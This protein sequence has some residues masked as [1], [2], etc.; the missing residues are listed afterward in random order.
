MSGIEPK[1]GMITFNAEGTEGGLYHSRKLHVPT[2][3]SGLTLGRGYDLRFKTKNEVTLDLTKIGLEKEQ[4]NQL[5]SATGL[6]GQQAKE[7]ISEHKL[8]SFELSPQQQVKLFEISYQKEQLETKRLCTK[9]DV[10][11]AY[12]RC[13]WSNLNK[14]IKEVLVDMKFRGD[15]TPIVRKKIQKTIS[16]NNTKGFYGVLDKRENWPNVPVD[17]FKRRV[18]YFKKLNNL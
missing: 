1:E 17:R 16:D 13:D 9:P 3:S 4:I 12:G 2:L 8:E 15:Y 14:G 10:E 18:E 5:S 7:F 6:A 11:R